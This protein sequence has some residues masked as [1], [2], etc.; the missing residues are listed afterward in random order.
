M[1]HTLVVSTRRFVWLCILFCLVVNPVFAQE[2]DDWGDE[3]SEEDSVGFA[4]TSIVD[5]SPALPNALSLRGYFKYR[6][7]LWVERPAAQM[8]S[9]S[10]MSTDVQ[11]RYSKKDFRTV[12]GVR[13]DHDSVY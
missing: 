8:P 4:E 3:G 2:S 10:R 1:L 11:L 13:F 7:G 9:T 6:L 12:A 5:T